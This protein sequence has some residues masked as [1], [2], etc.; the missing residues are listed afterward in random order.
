MEREEK[1]EKIR[2]QREE[3]KL[4]VGSEKLRVKTESE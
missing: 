4:I 2:Q 1:S 3:G